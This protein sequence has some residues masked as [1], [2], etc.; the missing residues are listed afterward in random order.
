[1]P[2]EEI[3]TRLDRV[4]ARGTDKWTAR[5]P[6]HADRSPSLSLRLAEDGRILAHCFAGCSIY[7]ICEALGITI[8][9]LFPDESTGRRRGKRKTIEPKPWRYDWRQT[10]T[11]FQFHADMLWLR[12][13]S[14]LDVAKRLNTAEWDDVDFDVAVQAVSRGYADRQRADFV[15][16]L[17]FHLCTQGL[18]KEA[19]QDAFR[20]GA[21]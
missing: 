4:R 6:A 10:A 8:V 2:V 21:A 16:K 14:V 13:Q 5:C 18:K 19:E 20:R 11:D 17:A 9:D 12:A 3:L 15:D 1:M 7:A